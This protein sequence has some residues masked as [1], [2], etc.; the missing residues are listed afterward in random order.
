[1]FFMGH[2]VGLYRPIGKKRVGGRRRGRR[3]IDEERGGRK[4]RGCF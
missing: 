4:E 1:M 3:K 2:S